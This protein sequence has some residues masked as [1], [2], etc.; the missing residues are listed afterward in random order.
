VED[1]DLPFADE[2]LARGQLLAGMEEE[3][4]RC[5]QKGRELGE[6]IVDPEDREHLFEALETLRR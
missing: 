6:Q 4:R 1:W 2:A 5:G 3:S